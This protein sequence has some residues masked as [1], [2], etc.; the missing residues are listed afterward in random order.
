MLVIEQNVNQVHFYRFSF[1]RFPIFVSG[2][3][4]WDKVECLTANST[5]FIK[6]Y[7]KINVVLILF[8]FF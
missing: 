1:P 8:V 3:G 4:F 6:K 5:T 7:G 2:N